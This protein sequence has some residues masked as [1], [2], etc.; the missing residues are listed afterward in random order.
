MII[1][2][3]IDDRLIHAQVAIGWGMALKPDRMIIADD[4]VASDD[5][6]RQLFMAAA[7]PDIKVSILSIRDT[8]EQVNGGVFDKERAILL[9]KGP[10]EALSLIELGLQAD[11]LNVG[12]MH[13]SDGKDK[14][15]DHVYLD[16]SDRKSF[17]ELVKRGLTLEARAL[18]GDEKVILNSKVV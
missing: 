5:W 1:L 10:K 4:E 13:F 3:R 16:E 6:E 15:L 7:S 17:R 2:F 9:V 11:E 8:V 18:P 14:V 12:G